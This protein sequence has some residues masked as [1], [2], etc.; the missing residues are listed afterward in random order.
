MTKVII[1]KNDNELVYIEIYGHANFSNYGNDVVC[2]GISAIVFGALNALVEYGLKDSRIIM[3]EAFIRVNLI[4]NQEIQLIAKTM[5]IQL[6]TI[7]E[8]FPDNIKISN[9]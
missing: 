4:T 3:D 6:K 9:V 7:Q 2:S 8:A 1:K 5:L